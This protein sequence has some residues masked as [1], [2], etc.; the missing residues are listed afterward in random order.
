M[1]PN[2]HVDHRE[3]WGGWSLIPGPEAF[4]E[5]LYSTLHHAIADYSPGAVAEALLRLPGVSLVHPAVPSW[6]Q[7]R[8]CWLGEGECLEF[9]MTLFEM[10]EEDLFGGFEL[11]GACAPRSL[12]QLW[13]ALRRDFPALWA[14]DPGCRIWQ[15][16]SLMASME[17]G[18]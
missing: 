18:R 3:D 5:P 9:A 17:T 1:D 6:W 14:H 15:P 2:A 12:L 10:G 8:A 13:R 11:E 16:D 4:E 7:W